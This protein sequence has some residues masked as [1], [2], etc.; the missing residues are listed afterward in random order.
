MEKHQTFRL[1]KAIFF[2]SAF[3][4]AMVFVFVACRHDSPLFPND[5]KPLTAK[6]EAAKKW[7]E[8]QQQIDGPTVQEMTPMWHKAFS[9]HNVVEVPFQEMEKLQFPPCTRIR[10]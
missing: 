8:S 1:G 4:A 3:F 2:F 10:V 5:N 6:V 7:F 9:V